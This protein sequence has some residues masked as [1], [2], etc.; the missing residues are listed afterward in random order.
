MDAQV[1][2]DLG[3][4]R[5]AE[6]VHVALGPEMDEGPEGSSVQLQRDGT[7]LVADIQAHDLSTLRAAMN[8]FVRLADAAR[9]AA[10]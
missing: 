5:V 9:R 4:P 10:S 2:L 8:S 6:A 3:D 7:R 1:A